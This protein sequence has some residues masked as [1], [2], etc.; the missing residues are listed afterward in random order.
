[1]E[2][3]KYTLEKSTAEKLERI[4]YILKTV[5]HPLRL[6]IVHL[7]EKHEQLSVSEITEGFQKINQGFRTST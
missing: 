4:A 1:M 7:L 2:L 5:A 3:Q 6:G